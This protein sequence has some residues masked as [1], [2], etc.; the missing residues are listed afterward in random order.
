MLISKE[1]EEKV[2]LIIQRMFYHNR[3]WDRFLAFSSVE[4]ALSNFNSV[5]HSN[6]AHLYPLLADVASDILLR[7]NIAPKYYETPSD[8]RTYGSLIDFFNINVNEHVETYELIKSAIDTATVNSDLNVETDLKNLL[9]IFNRFMEQAL[10]L[11][12]KAQIYGDNKIPEFDYACEQFY[13]LS[14]QRDMLT[15]KNIDD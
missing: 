1:T 15:N 2:N 10:L 7:Y 8:T 13:V 9:K 6:L 12:D 11:K 3:T 14:K 5:F 4:W